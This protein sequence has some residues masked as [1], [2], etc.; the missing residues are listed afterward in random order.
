MKAINA[1]RN[2]RPPAMPITAKRRDA[3]LDR[4]DIH[5]YPAAPGVRFTC[6][7]LLALA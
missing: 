7:I 2:T 6:A 4:D 1:I 3:F 5:Q